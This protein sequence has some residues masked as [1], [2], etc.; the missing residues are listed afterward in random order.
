[1]NDQ[2]SLP[3]ERTPFGGTA[4]VTCPDYPKPCSHPKGECPADQQAK[5]TRT[6][7]FKRIS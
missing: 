3:I 7:S 4:Y 1:M 6:A 5:E 2:R